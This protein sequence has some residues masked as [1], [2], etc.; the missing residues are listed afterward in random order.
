MAIIVKGSGSKPEEEKTVTAGT[1]AIVVSPSSGKVMKKVTVNPTPS[2]TKTVTPKAS[3]QT[4]SPSSGKLLS[5]VTVNGDADLVAKNVKKG[6]NIFGVTGTLVEGLDIDLSKFECTKYETGTITL[7]SSPGKNFTINHSLGIV[8]K[9]VIVSNPNPEV[10]NGYYRFVILAND[11]T[12]DGG[13]GVGEIAFRGD[14][15]SYGEYP[16]YAQ[17]RDGYLYEPNLTASKVQVGS[18]DSSFNIE[19]GTYNYL[20]MG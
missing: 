10:A 15:T 2:E 14:K 5:N 3:K 1:S 20:I 18:C 16:Y 12:S 17:R 6:I 11:H 13:R 19:N 8:P 4:V 7:A 9:Y